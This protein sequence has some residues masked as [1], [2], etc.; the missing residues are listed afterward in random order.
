M[1]NLPSQYP[2]LALHL[3][4]RA[5]TPL[6]TSA[7]AQ[8]QL[9]SLTALS[10]TALNAHESA[11]RLGL[12]IPQRIM[13]EHGEG[14]VFLQTFLS[15][16]PAPLVLSLPRDD[17]QHQTR[18]SAPDAGMSAA[19]AQLASLSVSSANGATQHSQAPPQN[20]RPQA[21][22]HQGALALA[23]ESRGATESGLAPATA[24]YLRGGAATDDEHEHSAFPEDEH[25][26]DNEENADA[27]PILVGIVVAPS[28]DETLEARRAAAR[29]ERVGREIQGRWAELQGQNQDPGGPDERQ[30]D[31]A[32]V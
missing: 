5:L 29:L 13:V 8:Q 9:Q 2:S 24:A 28:S 17:Q 32:G 1:A 19:V 6:I 30:G 21:Q 12:G 7:R 23:A 31:G 26:I 3:T 22:Q 16:Q 27:P 14:P 10:H 20:T 25:D 4:D 15:P 18:Q 11:L